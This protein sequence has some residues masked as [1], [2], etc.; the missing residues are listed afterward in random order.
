MS[1]LKMTMGVIVGN[2][3]FFPDVL[4]KTGREDVIEALA[5]AGIDAVVLSP[6]ESKYGAVETH[7][8]AKRCAELFRANAARIDGARKAISKPNSP[9]SAP[10]SGR[11][12]R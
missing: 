7:E 5:R 12:K 8:D 1:N 2:R 6:E 4:A 9:P 11:P 10:S 3:G